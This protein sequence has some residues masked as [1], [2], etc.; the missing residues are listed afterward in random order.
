MAKSGKVPRRRDNAWNQLAHAEKGVLQDQADN[1]ALALVLGHK[2]DTNCSTKTLA[3][4]KIFVVSGL[5]AIAEIVEG[6]LGVDVEPRFV[7]GARGDSVA[8]VFEHE[9]VAADGLEQHARN[10]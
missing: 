10:G 9:D 8:T 6:G 4:D 7:G 3:I 2:L 1:V 5:S